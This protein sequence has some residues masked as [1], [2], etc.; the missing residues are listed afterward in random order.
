[1]TGSG[2]W[3]AGLGVGITE[4]AIRAGTMAG[5]ETLIEAVT[6]VTAVSCG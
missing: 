3:G 6:G 4:D 5:V 1:V 2:S